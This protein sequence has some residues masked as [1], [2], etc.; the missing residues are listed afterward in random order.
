MPLLSRK[1]LPDVGEVVVGTVKEIYDYGAYLDVDEYGGLRAFLPW[2]EVSSRSFRSIDEVIK[3]NERVAVK[4]IRVN[5]VKG[6]VVLRPA[7]NIMSLTPIGLGVTPLASSLAASPSAPSL[8]VT[9]AFIAPC[10]LALSRASWT[11]SLQPSSKRPPGLTT[12]ARL[13]P[14]AGPALW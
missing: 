7:V 6:Q 12:P 8:T 10:L 4:V 11:E 1:P 2:S 13:N 14:P 9:T 5:K 3:V